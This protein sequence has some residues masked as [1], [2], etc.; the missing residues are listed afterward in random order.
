MVNHELLGWAY[1]KGMFTFHQKGER[2]FSCDFQNPYT[3]QDVVFKCRMDDPMEDYPLDDT[4]RFDP[5]VEVI[6]QA[7][8]NPETVGEAKVIEDT[9]RYICGEYGNFQDAYK[10]YDKDYLRS[11]DFA[12]HEE[13][14][15][16]VASHQPEA[17]SE[18]RRDFDIH[19]YHLP[20][21]VEEKEE[22]FDKFIDKLDAVRGK[23]TVPIVYAATTRFEHDGEPYDVLI[24]HED[25]AYIAPRS[26]Y[27]KQKGLLS[28]SD[29]E[30]KHILR[31]GTDADHTL[32]EFLSLDAFDESI[33]ECLEQNLHGG[34]D[35]FLQYFSLKEDLFVHDICDEDEPLI[36]N[37][38]PLK[39]QACIEAERQGYGTDLAQAWHGLDDYLILTSPDR[40]KEIFGDIIEKVAKNLKE[41]FHSVPSDRMPKTGREYLGFLQETQDA[42]IQAAGYNLAHSEFDDSSYFMERV[43]THLCHESQPYS[44]AQIQK[45]VQ[46]TLFPTIVRRKLHGKEAKDL[47]EGISNWLRN[48]DTREAATT[49]SDL[50]FGGEKR[51][52]L[53]KAIRR[54]LP[55]KKQNQGR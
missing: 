3:K 50:A 11:H 14:K 9:L 31:R 49:L 46:N 30:T 51:K 8:N 7:R 47:A 13:L 12:S 22:M 25:N 44:A 45:A 54:T 26:C 21:T 37:G 24:D 42:A 16:W 20:R 28:Y 33:E 18:M 55:Y 27:D 15:N 29:D 35:G 40:K 32:A 5:L 53:V 39:E 10:A 1:Y 43:A 38:I 17:I 19:F 41:D 52:V 2:D 36:V 4:G 34:R 23:T 6:E 48:S